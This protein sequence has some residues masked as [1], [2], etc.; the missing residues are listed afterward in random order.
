MPTILEPGIPNPWASLT[1]I[2]SSA[3]MASLG[4]R[5]C[6]RRCMLRRGSSGR[7][8]VDVAAV[9]AGGWVGLWR[10]RRDCRLCRSSRQGPMVWVFDSRVRV[11][12]RGAVFLVSCSLFPGCLAHGERV[13]VGE[14]A[15]DRPGARH[16]SGSCVGLGCSSS[17]FAALY[18]F[19]AS[20][21][22]SIWMSSPGR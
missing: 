15:S 3:G 6:R 4:A 2:S 14:V 5:T 7:Y 9:A 12:F 10:W 22:F 8:F 11:W 18:V 21:I 16:R 19:V 13:S 1:S 20:S 17:R